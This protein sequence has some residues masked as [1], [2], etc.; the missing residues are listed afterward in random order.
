MRFQVHWVSLIVVFLN[1]LDPPLKCLPK[2]IQA[3]N[4]SS[5]LKRPMYL[6]IPDISITNN[7]I[8]AVDYQVTY[9]FTMIQ[10]AEPGQDPLAVLKARTCEL[11]LH[12]F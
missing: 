1:F 4:V 2:F 9:D 6:F 11:R 3:N 10:G 8:I 7:F 5:V 12:S